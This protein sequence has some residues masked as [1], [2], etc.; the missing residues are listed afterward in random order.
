MV[1]HPFRF[2]LHLESLP[3]HA[4]RET[5]RYVEALGYSTI[6]VPD[7]FGPQWD[8]TALM[9]S[10]ASVTETLRVGALVHAID[11]RHPVIYAR[12]AAT[13]Q[14]LSGGR[15]EFGLGAGWK[16]SDYVEA[17]LLY[18]RIGV[19]I[20]RLDEALQICRA[21]WAQE[22]TSFE[23]KHYRI[24]RIARA[25][26]LPP[27]AEPKVLVG[28]GGR[29][30]LSLAG[31]RADI[32]GITATM[33]EGRVTAETA[34]DLSPDRTLEKVEWVRSAAAAAG[35]DVDAVEFSSLTLH[36]AIEDDASSLRRSLATSTGM[37]V[38]EVADCPL[39]LTGSASEIRDRLEVRRER[40]GISYIVIQSSDRATIERFAEHVVAPM[41]G[42]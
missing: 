36:V 7:H 31:R 30:V 13:I 25:V 19:R 12:Q 16:Q 42:A 5:V 1:A 10:A 27:G 41:N 35:R 4:W 40:T 23:G 9:V 39:F 2:G 3:A 8:P 18:D 37:S 17:G 22:S 11:Y 29:R 24:D 15:Y 32:V 20:E 28:G 6:L 38:D 26:E 21:M 34:A 14:L 33:K